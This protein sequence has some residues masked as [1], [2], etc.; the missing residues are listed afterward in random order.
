MRLYLDD[1]LANTLL[2][3]F[4]RKAGHDV[5]LPA[6]VGMAGQ[7]DAVHLTHTIRDNRVCLSRNYRDFRNLQNLIKE[8][9]GHHP[10]ILIVRRDNDPRRNLTPRDIVRAI[11]N[12]QAAGLPLADACYELNPWQ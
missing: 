12:L 1:D 10:G 2:A 11:R 4:L 7:D 8:A 9:Q 3:G 6:D 5:V